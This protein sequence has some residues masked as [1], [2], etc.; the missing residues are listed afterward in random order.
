MKNKKYNGK[1]PGEKDKNE[2]TKNNEPQN[3]A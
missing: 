2:G 1:T 3:A